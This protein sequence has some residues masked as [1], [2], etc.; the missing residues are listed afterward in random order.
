VGTFTVDVTGLTPATAY[1][2]RAFV[3]TSVGIVYSGV[4][5]FTTSAA[6]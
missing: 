6:V 4:E 1:R 5:S 2:F 3:R